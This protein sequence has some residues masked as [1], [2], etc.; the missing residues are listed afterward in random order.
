MKKTIMR[1]ALAAAALTAALPGSAFA[2]QGGDVV[3][4]GDFANV[5]ILR[6]VD[7]SDPATR[8][9]CSG[10]LVAPDVIITAAH[11]TEG[12]VDTVYY[13]F[14]NEV[15]TTSEPPAGAGWTFGASNAGTLPGTIHTDPAWDGDLQLN[16]LDDIGVIELAEPVHG[17]EPAEIAPLGYLDHVR[18]GTV[19]TVAGYGVSFDKPT[20]S[21]PQKPVADNLRVKRWTTAP[22]S[23]I[24][25]DTIKL[26]TNPKDGRAGGGTCFGDSGGPIFLG[27]Y[28]V[29]VTSWGTS[30]FCKA[31]QAGYQRLDTQ[32]AYD[33]YAPLVYG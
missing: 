17:I 18:T 26:A 6:F 28:L 14:A 13:S 15:A 10:T 1:A 16:E 8:W 20:S 19:F 9:R 23:N 22:M 32:D 5:A 31:G 33:F 7:S 3:T 29:G 25:R 2:I 27:G 11:C 21:G 12:P 4:D 30:Q 24:T